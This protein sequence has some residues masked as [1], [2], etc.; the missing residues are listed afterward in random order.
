VIKKAQAPSPRG[1]SEI[2]DQRRTK[3]GRGLGEIKKAQKKTQKRIKS[4]SARPQVPKEK[5][6]TKERIIKKAVS[7][8]AEQGDLL[9]ILGEHNTG[10]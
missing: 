9:H 4:S 8:G 7:C 5:A 6:I 10:V 2:V 3:G 1:N